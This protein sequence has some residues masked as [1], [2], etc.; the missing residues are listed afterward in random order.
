MT[1][2]ES[3]LGQVSWRG[4]ITGLIV[5]T[6]CLCAGLEVWFTQTMPTWFVAG[7]AS[8]TSVYAHQKGTNGQKD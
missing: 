3:R 7:F 5:L 1:T 6:G 8:A 4:W 2:T